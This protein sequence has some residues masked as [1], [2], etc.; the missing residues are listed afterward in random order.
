MWFLCNNVV[1]TYCVSVCISCPAYG[2]RYI[3]STIVTTQELRWAHLPVETKK[4][5]VHL[6]LS[7]GHTREAIGEFL[8]TTKDAIVGFQH[9]HLTKLT[10]QG[11]GKKSTVQLAHLETLLAAHQEKKGR[12]LPAPTS[13][14]KAVDT[15]VVSRKLTT[16][17]RK[18]CK[19]SEGCAY[20]CLPD[21]VSC[22]RPGHDT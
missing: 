7:D 8:G 18:Q 21:S 13:P 14:D 12:G 5:Y 19:H 3:R 20:E 9:R 16:D 17:W 11:T 4:L 6:L 10:G 2:G 15:R 22:G 1:S